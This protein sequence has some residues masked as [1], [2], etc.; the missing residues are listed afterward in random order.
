M[1]GATLRWN[2]TAA[3][4]KLMRQCTAAGFFNPERQ[5]RGPGVWVPRPGADGEPVPA[6]VVHAGD[7]LWLADGGAGAWR[8]AGTK[9]GDMFYA[10]SPL[11]RRPADKPL[12]AAEAHE[13][14][15]YLLRWNW[16]R[17]NTAALVNER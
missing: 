17:P 2:D 6:L 11:Q 7:G 10:A 16:R 1:R 4:A 15:D 8:T 9:V 5:V 3:A 13:I 14:L 12:S